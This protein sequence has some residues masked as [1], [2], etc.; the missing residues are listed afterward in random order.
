MEMKEL[1]KNDQ[2][3]ILGVSLQAGEA[4]PLHEAS[5]DAFVILK[6][7]RGRVSFSDRVV[8]LNAGESL[9]IKAHEPHKLE[10]LED[11]SS[12]IVLGSEAHID[13]IK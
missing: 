6:K 7:G 12:C 5:S 8:E 3:K 1:H 4:M 9:L 10:V 11:F 13:F 2:Y